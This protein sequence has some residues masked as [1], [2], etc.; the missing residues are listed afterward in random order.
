MHPIFL[1]VAL[2]VCA[3]DEQSKP[4]LQDLEINKAEL[5]ERQADYNYDP[6]WSPNFLFYVLWADAP[7]N[8]GKEWNIYVHP[9]NLKV[10]VNEHAAKPMLSA[11]GKGAGDG[12]L[13][14]LKAESATLYVKNQ[15][16]KNTWDRKL[17]YIKDNLRRGFNNMALAKLEG[18]NEGRVYLTV[19]DSF[20]DTDPFMILAKRDQISIVVNDQLE[21]GQRHVYT[22]GAEVF[23]KGGSYF[24]YA[25][26]TAESVTIAVASEEAA[27]ALRQEIA[28]LE[29]DE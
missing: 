24:K 6:I 21:P 29:V 15:K 16:T 18:W 17:Q 14:K 4:E 13:G 26:L 25:R 1:A 3:Q 23:Y 8:E 2:L 9:A 20:W 7:E 5:A 19:N 28:E 27:E 12:Y 11:K 10:E 22:A